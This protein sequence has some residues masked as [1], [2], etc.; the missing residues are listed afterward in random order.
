MF[1]TLLVADQFKLRVFE[2]LVSEIEQSQFPVWSSKHCWLAKIVV[3]VTDKV[4][5]DS[6]VS[7]TW[8]V[9]VFDPILKVT[10]PVYVP[11]A[12]R[13]FKLE[14]LIETLLEAPAFNMPVVAL[15]NNQFPPLFVCVT[16]DQAPAGPQLVIATVCA[17]GSRTFAAPLKL[18]VF[19]LP[20]T[21]LPCTVKDICKDF[22]EMP[23]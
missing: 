14:A 7:V 23:G 2:L 13:A 22:V 1:F 16:A 11:A 15:A 8:I 4:G 12:S 10:F 18:S 6:T 5:G 19:G 17:T 20:E 9:N 3:G 21:Q